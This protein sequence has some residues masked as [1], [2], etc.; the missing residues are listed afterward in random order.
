[1]AESSFS[2]RR[3]NTILYCRAWQATVAFYR[4]R[5]GLAVS[6]E[7]EWFVEFV[8]NDG[9]ALSVADAS[10]ATVAAAE[11]QGITLALQVDDLSVLHDWLAST[12]TPV[13]TIRQRWGAWVFYCH[14]PEG[15]RIEFWSER[16][17]A[18]NA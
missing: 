11:G 15:H 6:F 2:V 18:T 17:P 1:M 12:E 13:T 3:A 14:D 7:N 8:L 4:V 5:L 16:A 10:R 9:A